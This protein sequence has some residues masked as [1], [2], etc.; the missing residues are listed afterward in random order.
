[1]FQ[2]NTESVIV[3]NPIHHTGIQQK[4]SKL[5]ALD[6]ELNSG[7]LEFVDVEFTTQQEHTHT[8]VLGKSDELHS[9][10]SKSNYDETYSNVASTSASSGALSAHLIIVK[11]L[12]TSMT[13]WRFVV[14]SLFL[15]N[16]K[17]IF[18]HLDA[19]LPTYLVRTFGPGV[20][21]GTIY[22][23]NPFMIMFLTPVVS[24]LTTQYAHYDMIKYGGYL[25]AISP[26]FL[27]ISESIWAAVMFVVVLSLGEAIWSPRTYDYT[28]SIAPEVN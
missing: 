6:E 9:E 18:R 7:D 3:S 11:E 4:Y 21:K 25:S 16:L 13:F 20:P 1:M 26:F 17:A 10:Q 5:N 19:T 27:A 12:F 2:E 28:M 15:I 24:A 8:N 23:I 22:G 14:L